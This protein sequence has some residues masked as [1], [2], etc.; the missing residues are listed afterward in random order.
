[1]LGQCV[2][3]LKI[4]RT[5]SAIAA[6]LVNLT[7]FL[8]ICADEPTP[9]EKIDH[10]HNTLM[11][12]MG[13]PDDL[14][15]RL[16]KLTPEIAALFDIKTISRISLG[17]TW[18]TLSPTNQETFMELLK[19]LITTTYA[20]RFDTYNGQKFRNISSQPARNGIMVKTEIERSN[21]ERIQLDYYFRDAFAYNVVADGVSDLSLRRADYNAIIKKEGFDSLLSHI[22]KN[23]ETQRANY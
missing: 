9:S 15:T 8:S 6:V 7:V 12:V 17:R 23:I 11:D 10:F 22:E 18:R 1:M 16:T 4:N 14:E 2:L 13:M 19:E 3:K 5:K 20:A 21:G